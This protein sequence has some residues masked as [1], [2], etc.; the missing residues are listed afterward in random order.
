MW[1]GCHLLAKVQFQCLNS[2]FQEIRMEM[3]KRSENRF[4]RPVYFGQEGVRCTLEQQRGRDTQKT[5]IAQSPKVIQKH[6]SNILLIK[7]SI[8]Y[9]SERQDSFAIVYISYL[10]PSC[11]LIFSFLFSQLTKLPQLHLQKAS[12][13]GWNMVRSHLGTLLHNINP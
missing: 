7:F 13:D 9:V 2:P 5:T 3:G 10:C 4:S 11:K 8:L 1:L 6:F 12:K